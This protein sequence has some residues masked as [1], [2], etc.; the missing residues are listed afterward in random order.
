MKSESDKDFHKRLQVV[1]LETNK[2]PFVWAK[3]A[4][5]P[6]ATFNRIWNDAQIP[7]YDNL[8]K[9][10]KFSGVS[11]DW[12]LLGKANKPADYSEASKESEFITIPRV[13]IQLAAG[14]GVL[15]GDHVEKLDEIPFTR[16][17]LGRKLGRTKTDGL[18]ILTADGDSM[19][20]L[21]SDGDLV[22]VDRKRNTL[23]D[24]VY[25]FVYGGMARVK[26]LRATLSGDIEVISQ[27]PEYKDELLKRSELDDFHIIGKVVWCGHRFS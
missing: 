20:P 5:I 15:N 23:S 3:E 2:D 13:D 8:I 19:D 10:A 14:G 26:K 22:M 21:I 16:Q 27:N 9:I 4:G 18:V 25:A 24:G 6:N 1:I 12:L 11:L 7:K 17:F